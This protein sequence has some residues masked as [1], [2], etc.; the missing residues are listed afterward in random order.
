LNLG[1]PRWCF[2]RRNRLVKSSEYQ[3]V[4][5]HKTQRL[6][7]GGLNILARAN[8]LAYARIGIVVSSRVARRAVAR[9]RIKRIV[10]ESFRLHQARLQG[11]DIVV[12]ARS[13]VVKQS[14][15]E[16]FASLE[17]HWKKLEQCARSSST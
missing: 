7:G 17:G 10:R 5:D 2:N 16:L 11:W 13:G 6:S 3:S 9:N 1:R 4:F 12:I 15:Q 14:N 8:L